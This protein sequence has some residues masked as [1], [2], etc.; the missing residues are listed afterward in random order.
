MFALVYRRV[1]EPHIYSFKTVM[2]HRHRD[3]HLYSCYPPANCFSTVTPHQIQ[4]TAFIHALLLHFSLSFI[5]NP[6]VSFRFYVFCSKSVCCFVFLAWWLMLQHVRNATGPA[7]KTHQSYE[8]Q[9][10]S[11]MHAHTAVPKRMSLLGNF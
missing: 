2:L 4:L 1:A 11:H 6:A 3:V 9:D 10:E 7:E 5:H 8:R